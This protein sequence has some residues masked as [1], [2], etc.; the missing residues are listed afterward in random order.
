MAINNKNLA[1]SN[2]QTRAMKRFEDFVDNNNKIFILNGYAGTGKT[3]LVKEMIKWLGENSKPY[4]LL[5]STGRAAQILSS[6]TNVPAST[7]HGSIYVYKDFNQDVDKIV[8]ERQN[9]GVDSKGQLYLDF[10]LLTVEAQQQ[11]IYIV[12]EASMISDKKDTASFQATFGSG[13]LLHD[14][15]LHDPKGKLCLWVTPASCHQSIKASLRHCR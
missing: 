2:D 10:K 4:C 11:I 3:T 14:L 15:L 1:L 12:D 7:V 6:K 5:A 9:T 8:D 13:C